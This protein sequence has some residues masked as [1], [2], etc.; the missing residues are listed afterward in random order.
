MG[1]G[2]LERR[3]LEILIAFGSS[4]CCQ[5][6]SHERECVMMWRWQGQG[7]LNSLGDVPGIMG[8]KVLPSLCFI[9]IVF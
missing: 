2:G 4:Q 6:S 5:I 3:G 8:V 9:V 7:A 1:A